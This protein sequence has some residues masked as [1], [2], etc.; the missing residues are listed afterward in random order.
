MNLTSLQA[1]TWL[2]KSLSAKNTTT[3]IPDSYK[4]KV[5]I[6]YTSSSK[7]T[8]L[9][10][11]RTKVP[12]T[13]A[14]QYG[15]CQLML[16]SQIMQY[17]YRYQHMIVAAKSMRKDYKNT[18]QRGGVCRQTHTPRHRSLENGVNIYVT[19]LFWRDNAML[20][21]RSLCYV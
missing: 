13:R 12:I 19:Y 11:L 21:Q 18:S 1:P 17:S 14:L 2:V 3:S 6:A 15:S 16:T 4:A 20:Q 7:H 5:K 8:P 10:H 9:F